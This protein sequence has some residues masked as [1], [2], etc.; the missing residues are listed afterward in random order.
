MSEMYI[1]MQE[2]YYSDESARKKIVAHLTPG[3]TPEI[4]KHQYK[5]HCQSS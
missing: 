2:A 1:H 3:S 4:R 5:E